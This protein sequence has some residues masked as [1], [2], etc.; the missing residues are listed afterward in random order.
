VKAQAERTKNEAIAARETDASANE[1]RAVIGAAPVVS[2]SVGKDDDEDEDV[3]LCCD[4]VTVVTSYVAESVDVVLSLELVSVLISALVESSDVLL[5]SL[6]AASVAAEDVEP[7]VAA[8]DDAAPE[9]PPTREPVPHG[10][11]SPLG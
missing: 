8:P 7:V 6:D 4:C 1:G 11:A 9:L 2:E 3:V 10:I 5:S